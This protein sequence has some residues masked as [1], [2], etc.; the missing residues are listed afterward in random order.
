MILRR[1][2]LAAVLFWPMGH[3][4][5]LAAAPA[6]ENQPTAENAA[7]EMDPYIVT[8][9]PQRSGVWNHVLKSL[10]TAIGKKF[11]NMRGGPLLD[12]I[13]YR[14]N[15][16][17]DHPGEHAIVIV[18][19]EPEHGRVTAATVVYTAKGDLFASS[20]ALGNHLRLRGFTAKDI[21]NP[22]RIR[23]E[24]QARRDAYLLAA[25]YRN[26]AH[27]SIEAL[28]V[29]QDLQASRAQGASR[30]PAPGFSALDS[31]QLESDSITAAGTVLALAEETGDYTGIYGAGQPALENEYG[32]TDA[33]ELMEVAYGNLH[34]G[35]RL[36]IA[37][38]KIA[39]S[40][41]SRTD[42]AAIVS[43]KE[44]VII[45]DWDQVHY[46]FNPDLGT[47]GVPIP[48]NLATGLPSL[49]VKHGE[50]LEA[51]YFFATYRALHPGERV[52][53]LP[54]QDS[55]HIGVAYTD[56]GKLWIYSPAGGRFAL[57]DRFHIEDL[58]TLT[59]VH[60]RLLDN[61]LASGQRPKTATLDELPGDTPDVQTRRALLAL[62]QAGFTCK[63]ETVQKT[64]R[65]T[66]T[67]PN[68]VYTYSAP[69]R[70]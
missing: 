38:A 6:A 16:L 8:A 19:S 49:V 15:Y 33:D 36:P 41:V 17:R 53:L 26:E 68:G 10:D 14:T 44:D 69:A 59:A 7:I 23:K 35:T 70:S 55:R 11:M 5:R 45:F 30:A 56:R 1:S 47:Y 2:L 43:K 12:A 57:P 48:K 37:R 25:G 58:K 61:A 22:E 46:L 18:S 66:V 13:F 50:A 34:A 65:L 42:P 51:L 63:L 40:E 28:G 31:V 4:V 67:W 39:L 32:S 29:L 64:L 62:Q 3:V 52:Q 60:A 20:A 9:P 21:D 27:A 54:A 24:L